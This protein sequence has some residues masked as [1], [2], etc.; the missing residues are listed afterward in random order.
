MALVS[1]PGKG[2][3]LQS[4]W[5][6]QEEWAMRTI[7]VGRRSL[8]GL[9]ALG[10]LSIAAPASAGGSISYQELPLPPGKVTLFEPDQGMSIQQYC[11]LQQYVCRNLAENPSR[12]SP[13]VV[14]THQDLLNSELKDAFR[15]RVPR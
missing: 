6:G 7:L 2:A 4:G 10:A 11:V 14:S 5:R 12:G 8:L 3:Y 13:D 1:R 9:A 15:Q